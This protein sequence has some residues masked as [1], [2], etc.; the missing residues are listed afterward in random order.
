MQNYFPKGLRRNFKF[1]W[2]EMKLTT[3]ITWLFLSAVNTDIFVYFLLQMW[4]IELTESTN[5]FCT[6]DRAVRTIK[7]NMKGRFIGNDVFLQIFMWWINCSQII[8]ELLLDKFRIWWEKDRFLLLFLPLRT[9]WTYV[10][11]GWCYKVLQSIRTW[12]MNL[13]TLSYPLKNVKRFVT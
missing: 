9:T 8:K 6:S 1:T 4:T 11:Q 13:L 12:K 10:N 5:N 2:N 3:D 7:I